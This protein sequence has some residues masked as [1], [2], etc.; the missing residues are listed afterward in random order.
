MKDE[1]KKNRKKWMK[2]NSAFLNLGGLFFGTLL[3][4]IFIYIFQGELKFE[5]LIVVSI[6]LMIMAI[7]IIIRRK[8]QKN[9]IPE[10]DERIK[11]NMFKVHFYMSHIF[12]AILFLTIGILTLSGKKSVPLSYLWIFFFSFITISGIGGVITKKI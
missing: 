7:I 8:L 1:N 9:N 5:G 6:T 10:V 11:M 2:K 3:A 12:L 4:T